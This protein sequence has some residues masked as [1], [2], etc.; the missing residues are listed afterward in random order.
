MHK[1][2]NVLRDAEKS[3]L[4][5]SIFLIFISILSYW[6]S[7]G[8]IISDVN[9]IVGALMLPYLCIAQKGNN[10]VGFYTILAVL[11]II[12][13][14][15]LPSRT[16]H[17]FSLTFSILSFIE[18]ASCVGNWLDVVFDGKFQFSF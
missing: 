3:F 11:S 5:I 7:I 12:S 13:S 10:K 9:F 15:I 16:L 14:F 8:Y 6:L 18:M 17:F 2:I 4:S 1:I